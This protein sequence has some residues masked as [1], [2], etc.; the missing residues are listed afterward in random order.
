VLDLHAFLCPGHVLVN[1]LHHI[2]GLKCCRGGSLVHIHTNAFSWG[3]GTWRCS[4]TSG[5]CTSTGTSPYVNKL[6]F[7]FLSSFPFCEKEIF[8]WKRGNIKDSAL[9]FFCWGRYLKIHIRELLMLSQWNNSVKRNVVA[10]SPP[11]AI[12]SKLA[13]WICLCQIIWPFS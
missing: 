8:P 10:K 5:E 4:Q 3:R 9:G 13:V 12:F 6:S 2:I 11:I 7:Y 1:L